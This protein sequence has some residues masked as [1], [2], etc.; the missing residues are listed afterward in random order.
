[1]VSRDCGGP[2]PWGRSEA[3]ASGCGG[4]VAGVWWCAWLLL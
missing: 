3:P 1:M 4:C 2:A